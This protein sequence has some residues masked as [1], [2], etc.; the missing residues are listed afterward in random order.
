[1]T[2]PW[3]IDVHHHFVPSFWAE[4]LPEHG[5]DPSGSSAPSWTPETDLLQMDELGIGTA[6][7]SLT[8]PGV[9]GWRGADQA[10]MARRINDCAAEVGARHPG[11]FGSFAAVPMDRPDAALREIERALDH[12]GADGITLLSNY[13]GDYLGHARF[14]V[15]WH[16]LDARGAVVFI[17]PTMPLVDLV[18]GLPGPMLD[19]PFDT[20]RTAASLLA[21]GVTTRHTRMKVILSHAGGF[22]PYGAYRMAG[23]IAGAQPDRS[24]QSLIA[25][26]KHF[27]YDVALSSSPSALPCLLEFAESD[28]ILFGSDVPYARA[29]RAAWF[30]RQ[31][32]ESPHLSTDLRARINRPNAE[33]LLPRFA[34]QPA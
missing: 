2:N 23:S 34:R 21:A 24:A 13:G 6:I 29:S 17:H 10:E 11:R 5:G 8:T 19:F 31:F 3:R 22:L 20:T 16:E 30:T 15:I 32:D 12:L 33:A 4:A 14:D 28:R 7:L 18:P 9:S 27:Y 25:E 1:M 26:M